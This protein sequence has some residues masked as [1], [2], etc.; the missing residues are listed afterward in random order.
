[1][2]TFALLLA[3]Q[4]ADFITTYVGMTL[5]STYITESN[6]LVRQLMEAGKTFPND[7][8]WLPVLAVKIGTAA[9]VALILRFIRPGKIAHAIFVSAYMM[10]GLVPAINNTYILW[11]LTRLVK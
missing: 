7:L 4:L 8:A 10:A 11:L 1:M 6:P 9:F 2:R 5:Y 3:S